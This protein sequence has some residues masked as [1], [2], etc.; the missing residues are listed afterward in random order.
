MKWGGKG[1]GPLDIIKTLAVKQDL[2]AG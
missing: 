2:Y 1:A